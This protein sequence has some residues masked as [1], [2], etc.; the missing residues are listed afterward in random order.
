MTQQLRRWSDKVDTT[1]LRRWSDKAS[2][3]LKSTGEV[4]K[5]G[6]NTVYAQAMNHPRTAVAVMLGSGV[7]AAILW[8]VK[9]NG[10]YAAAHRNTVA[11]VRRAP[12]RSR[13]AR[14]SA[15]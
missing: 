2:D 15:K 7:A 3:G 6:M 11:R 9:R 14:A 13:N 1:L 8:M 5:S 10:S 4:A 12:G